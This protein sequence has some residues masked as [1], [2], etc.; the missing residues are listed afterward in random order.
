MV[1]LK[2]IV[3]SVEEAREINLHST[4]VLLKLGDEIVI[5][6]DGLEF[7]FHYGLI[8]T[9]LRMPLCLPE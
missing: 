5:T 1:L 2:H 6:V 8:K 7:T 9:L 3:T 4:M